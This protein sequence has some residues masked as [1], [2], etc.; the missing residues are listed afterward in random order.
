MGGGGDGIIE[1][2]TRGLGVFN[3]P[4]N[5]EEVVRGEIFTAAPL[6]SV[7]LELKLFSIPGLQPRVEGKPQGFEACRGQSIEAEP[8]QVT[9]GF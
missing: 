2:T 9:W 7:T 6:P 3:T 5:R 4:Q 1:V 8:G